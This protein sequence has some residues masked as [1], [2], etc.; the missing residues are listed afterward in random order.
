MNFPR[1]EPNTGQPHECI[2]VSP[3]DRGDA[4]TVATAALPN[5]DEGGPEIICSRRQFRHRQLRLDFGTTLGGARPLQQAFQRVAQA[6]ALLVSRP[7]R[8]DALRVLQKS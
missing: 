4:E 7:E 2:D 8:K 5:S 3:F 6:V 1:R